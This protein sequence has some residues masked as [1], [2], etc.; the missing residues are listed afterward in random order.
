MKL[1]SITRILEKVDK[2]QWEELAGSLVIQ[3]H[4]LRERW[5]VQQRTHHHWSWSLQGL[6]TATSPVKSHHYR[7]EQGQYENPLPSETDFLFN[8]MTTLYITGLLR[9]FERPS[10]VEE[11]ASGHCAVATVFLAP[12]CKSWTNE[13]VWPF[14]WV[15]NGCLLHH[16]QTVSHTPNWLWGFPPAPRVLLLAI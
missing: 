7:Q 4:P 13:L 1:W 9:Y 5:S 15:G 11:P 10:I 6:N 12:G 16:Y 3:G 14:G 8:S 2:E